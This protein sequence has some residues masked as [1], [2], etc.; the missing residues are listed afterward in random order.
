[1]ACSHACAAVVNEMRPAAALPSIRWSYVEQ[2]GEPRDTSVTELTLL[3]TLAHLRA[4]ASGT[5]S[6]TPD[7]PDDNQPTSAVAELRFLTGARRFKNT[8]RRQ[9]MAK[10]FDKE[11]WLEA[12]EAKLEGAKQALKEG[13][14]K[15]KTSN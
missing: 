12:K 13:L 1:M 8:R 6:A 5:G 14:K 11:A 9:N 2:R 7:E 15:L 3:L 10:A 4:S